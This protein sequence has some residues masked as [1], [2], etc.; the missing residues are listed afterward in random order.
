[1]GF[2][3]QDHHRCLSKPLPKHCY[4]LRQFS[5]QSSYFYFIFWTTCPVYGWIQIPVS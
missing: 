1:L 5:H 4:G 2:I 3:H